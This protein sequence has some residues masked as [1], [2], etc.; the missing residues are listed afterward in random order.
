M[1]GNIIWIVLGAIGE[2][3]GKSAKFWKQIRIF[4]KHLEN[5]RKI[6]HAIFHI[7]AEKQRKSTNL[8]KPKLS[9]AIRL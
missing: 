2:N 8:R 6:K 4:E 9:R 5:Q 7:F 1:L 3:V